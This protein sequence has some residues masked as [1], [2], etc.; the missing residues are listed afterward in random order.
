LTLLASLKQD[1]E[2]YEQDFPGVRIQELKGV[3]KA[4][5]Y[6][7]KANNSMSFV[8]VGKSEN[9]SIALSKNNVIEDDYEEFKFDDE[10]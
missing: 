8:D 6:Q 4:M 10:E 2:D 5:N 1:A 3:L 7:F 9:S